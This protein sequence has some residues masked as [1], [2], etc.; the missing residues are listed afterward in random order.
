[1]KQ[2]VSNQGASA[3]SSRCVC[4]R[5]CGHCPGRPSLT[6][7]QP[8]EH[9][10]EKSEADSNSSKPLVEKNATVSGILLPVFSCDMS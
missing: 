1:M 8:Q 3:A 5:V 9:K 6:H 10:A 2:A 4:V 7:A